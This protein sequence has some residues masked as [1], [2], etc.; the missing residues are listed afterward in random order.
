MIAHAQLA[1]ELQL[2][3]Q[4]VCDIAREYD[5][6]YIGRVSGPEL[7]LNVRPMYL[8]GAA[9]DPESIRNVLIRQS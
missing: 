2:L 5:A 9:A 4:T 7:F 8:D 1:R 3:A 6:H